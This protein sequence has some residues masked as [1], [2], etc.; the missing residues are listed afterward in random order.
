MSK[1]NIDIAFKFAEAP[2]RPNPAADEYLPV[3]P[4]RPTQQTA[5]QQDKVTDAGAAFY[6]VTGIVLGALVVGALIRW[7]SFYN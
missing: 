4:A 1:D 3:I 7:Y 5:K 2:R 6:L